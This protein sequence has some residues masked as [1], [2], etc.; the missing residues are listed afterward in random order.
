M[1]LQAIERLIDHYVS[2]RTRIAICFAVEL[3]VFARANARRLQ[4]HFAVDNY[5]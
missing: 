5:G 3:V 1:A 4:N 2:L